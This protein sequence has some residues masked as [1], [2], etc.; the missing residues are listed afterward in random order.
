MLAQS[1]CILIPCLNEEDGIVSVV[2]AFQ[3]QF[4]L[5]R[6]LV[7]DNG[8]SDNT[9]ARARQAGAEVI[10]EPQ[11]GKARAVLSAFTAMNEDIVIMVDGDDTYPAEGAQRLLEIF[12]N[13]RADMVTGIRKSSPISQSPFRPMHQAGTSAFARVLGLVFNYR[14]GDV[15]SGLRLFTKRFYKNVPIHSRGFELEMELTIQAI[16]KGFRM[17]EAEVPYRGRAKGSESKLRTVHDGLRILR[18]LLVLFRDYKPLTFFSWLSLMILIAGLLAGSL[19]IYEYV[20]TRWVGRFPLAMLA[21]ALCNL[22]AFTFFTGLV[23]E[24]NLRH[25]RETYQ[26]DLRKFS[27]SP[28]DLSTQRDRASNQQTRA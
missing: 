1:L 8:S 10:I 18:L 6:I 12:Q 26:V 25:R 15:F 21:A 23:L 16:D 2:S 20:T 17:S 7:V 27:S 22:A 28:M 11:R 14:P 5:A 13:D 19:P 24:S 3:G 4:P 9:V